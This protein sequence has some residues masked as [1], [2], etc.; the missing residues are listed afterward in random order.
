MMFQG[1]FMDQDEVDIMVEQ[2]ARGL[3]IARVLHRGTGTVKIS[4]L[5]PEKEQA[6]AD[7]S[8]G[9]IELLK[10]RLQGLGEK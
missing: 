7:A 8:K 3:W 4:D 2:D 1:R 9:L 6:I 10:E 5:F